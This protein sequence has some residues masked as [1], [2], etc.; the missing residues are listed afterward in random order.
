MAAVST[1]VTVVGMVVAAYSAQQQQS[2]QKKAMAQQQQAA[3]EQKKA[4]EEQK[5][6]QDAQA[7]AERRAQIRE[8]RVKRAR[9]VQASQNTGVGDSS[10][11]IGGVGSSATQLGSNLGFNIGQREA[12]SNISDY[13]QNAA[14]FLSSAQSSM[15]SA[16]NWGQVGSLGT[17][18]FQAGGGF[19]TLGKAVSGT[20]APAPVVDKSTRN[21]TAGM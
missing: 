14:D 15:N 1:I 20:Q 6:A 4:R 8:E 2:A 18:I 12:A 10:G 16:A 9:V 17:S 13:N 7:A 21:T 5:A 11:E 19:N 3:D